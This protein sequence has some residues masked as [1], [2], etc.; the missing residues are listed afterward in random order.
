M[1]R[2]LPI[3]GQASQCRTFPPI[4]HL[5][6]VIFGFISRKCNVKNGNGGSMK[7]KEE[8]ACFALGWSSTEN[9]GGQKV[10]KN[11]SFSASNGQNAGMG[12]KL[13][14]LDGFMPGRNCCQ[15]QF[16]RSNFDFELLKYKRNLKKN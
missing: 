15:L 3:L 14:S 1:I 7:I 10:K 6:D 2:I 9:K 12:T 8:K 13:P 16:S 4:S 11:N 5:I